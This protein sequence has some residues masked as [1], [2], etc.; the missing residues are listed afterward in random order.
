MNPEEA[1]EII[2]DFLDN[3][4][5]PPKLRTALSVAKD[6]LEKQILLKSKVDKIKDLLE[7]SN[8]I[9]NNSRD[10]FDDYYFYGKACAYEYVLEIL[11]DVNK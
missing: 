11:G 10:I 1:I 3:H 2:N 5:T 9:S 6:T 7:T 8:A 4:Y